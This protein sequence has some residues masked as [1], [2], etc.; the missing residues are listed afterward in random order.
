M[1]KNIEK[2]IFQ[3]YDSEKRKEMLK[4]NCDEA[5]SN[6]SYVKK[7]SSEKIEELK[8]ELSEVSIEQDNK[9]E[10]LKELSKGL[11][12]EIKPLKEQKKRLLKNLR[13]KSEMINETVFVLKDDA[14]YN[15]YNSEGELLETRK[16]KPNEIQK[17]IFQ[18][19]RKTGTNN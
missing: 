8:D 13:E 5:I 16:L 11:K 14:N 15:V 2:L 1:N 9:E 17:T 3:E 18:Q 4:D 12:E 10:E 7:F 6:Y 19:I